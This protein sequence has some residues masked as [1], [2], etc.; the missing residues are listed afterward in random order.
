MNEADILLMEKLDTPKLSKSRK[1]FPVAV[2]ACPALKRTYNGTQSEKRNYFV[3][4]VVKKC[5]L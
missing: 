1:N 5:P 4:S 3:D 2:Y